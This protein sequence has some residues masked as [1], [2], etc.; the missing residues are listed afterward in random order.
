[1]TIKWLNI[2]LLS[3]FFCVFFLVSYMHTP[4]G[5]YYTDYSLTEVL[6]LS[7]K[8]DDMVIYFARSDCPECQKVDEI[9]QLKSGKLNEN[10]YR[11]DTRSE[12]NRLKLNTALTSF[13]IEKVPSFVAIR[14]QNKRKMNQNEVKKMLE[15]Q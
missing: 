2:L 8:D 6:T 4:R 7:K 3:L 1:M 5:K 10:V 12:Q 14:Q 15:K 9:L 13:G 11:I